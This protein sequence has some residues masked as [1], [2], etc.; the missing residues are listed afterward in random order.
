[1]SSSPWAIAEDMAARR[2]TGV[3]CD[4]TLFVAVDS[5][6][7]SGF[8]YRSC[9]LN[10][11]FGVPDDPDTDVQIPSDD[12]KNE[13]MPFEE[14]VQRIDLKGYQWLMCGDGFSLVYIGFVPD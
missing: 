8:E 7:F 3:P 14:V 11:Y 6:A 1:M 5:M 10:Y 2:W 12:D 13:P 4:H 9:L